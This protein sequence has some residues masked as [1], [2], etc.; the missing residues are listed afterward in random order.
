MGLISRKSTGKLTVMSVSGMALI[1]ASGCATV[2][3]TLPVMIDQLPI[4]TAGPG[5]SFDGDNDSLKVLLGGSGLAFVAWVGCQALGGGDTACIAAAVVAGGVGA[6]A[7]SA[8]QDEIGEELPAEDNRTRGEE[9]GKARE[10]GEVTEYETSAGPGRIEA[11]DTFTNDKGDQC[12]TSVETVD[13]G[14]R[15]RTVT[16]EICTDKDNPE[17][18][19]PNGV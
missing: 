15:V 18:T 13:F 9:L 19:Y 7:I 12:V 1:G 10:V 16:H 3:E 11:T 14:D 4:G 5:E 6:L 17:K 8:S 2:L